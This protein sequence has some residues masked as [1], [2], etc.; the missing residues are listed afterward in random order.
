MMKLIKKIR[1]WVEARIKAKAREKARKRAKKLLVKLVCLVL[2]CCG[3]AVVY[4][5]RYEIAAKIINRKLESKA[6]A[7]CPLFFKIFGKD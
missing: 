4:N 6:R 5:F 7:K 1:E 2:V 3:V